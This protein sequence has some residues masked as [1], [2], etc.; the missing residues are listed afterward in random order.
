MA[1][2][3]YAD[4]IVILVPATSALDRMLNRADKFPVANDIKFDSSKSELLV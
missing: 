2:F 4:D 1:A 3:V